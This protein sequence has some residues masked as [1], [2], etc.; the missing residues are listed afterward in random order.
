MDETPYPLT[1][2]PGWQRESITQY[3]DAVRANQFATFHNKRIVV[4]DICRLDRGFAETLEGWR[5]PD[6]FFP[7][8]LLL[9][10]HAAFRASAGLAM[11]GQGAEAPCLRRLTLECAGYAAMIHRDES[12][13]EVWLRRSD[14]EQARNQVRAMFNIG[15]MTV[16]VRQLDTTLADVFSRLYEDAIDFGAH[17]NE[18]MM[19]SNLK[20][21]RQGDVCLLQSIYLQG[22]GM[23]LDVA[24]KR[25][26]QVGLWC[27]K[28][29]VALYPARTA[30]FGISAAINE[31]APRY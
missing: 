16:A 29:F 31:I 21:E 1:P 20:M 22:E 9:R 2:P 26:V 11:A 14:N 23:A 28:V 3:L 30:E 17:P 5:D 7:A 18:L 8:L 13:A 19:T 10:S 15:R 12:L 27:A 4:Q 6:P 24:L 25:T